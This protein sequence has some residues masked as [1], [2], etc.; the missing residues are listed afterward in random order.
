LVYF[1]NNFFIAADKK[2]ID[3]LKKH[4]WS[5]YYCSPLSPVCTQ[6]IISAFEV[7]LG[8]DGTN[9]GAQKIKTLY[10]NSVYF[11]EELKKK[12]FEVLGDENSPVIC[13]MIYH[14]S[15]LG[16]FSRECLKRGVAVGK[17]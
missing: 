17:I 3:Y 5:Q 10:E 2:I 7:I 14:F 15:K 1:K 6:Q 16:G 11:K 9:I 12:G 13:L 8:E 4:S